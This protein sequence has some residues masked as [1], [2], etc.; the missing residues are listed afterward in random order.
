M[1]DSKETRGDS[2]KNIQ[3]EI[4]NQINIEKNLVAEGNEEVSNMYKVARK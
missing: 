1:Q 4:T 3:T 2:N